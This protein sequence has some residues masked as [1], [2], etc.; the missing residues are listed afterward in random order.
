MTRPFRIGNMGFY[1]RDIEKVASYKD[2]IILVIMKFR[3][4][5]DDAIIQTFKSTQLRDDKMKELNEI[6]KDE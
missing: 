5:P 4:H 2:N 1:K 6:L 3:A